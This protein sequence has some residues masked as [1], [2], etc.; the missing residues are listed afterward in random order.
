MC[1]L[2]VAHSQNLCCRLGWSHWT[3]QAAR[4]LQQRRAEQEPIRPE[5]RGEE[6]HDISRPWLLQ[7]LLLSKT[8]QN[9]TGP[10]CC[11]GTLQS[12]S[13]MGPW[14]PTMAA[15]VVGYKRATPL[16]IGKHCLNTHLEVHIIQ[17]SSDNHLAS[18]PTDLSVDVANHCHASFGV[19]ITHLHTHTSVERQTLHGTPILSYPI[20]CLSY[21]Q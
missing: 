3:H 4:M 15:V 19:P 20:L 17:V 14:K 18:I 7:Y 10:L 11:G 13:M 6:N 16:H 2:C 9:T 21:S 5:Q 8:R 12:L 1:S